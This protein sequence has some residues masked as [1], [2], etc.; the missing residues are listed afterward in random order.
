MRIDKLELRRFGKFTDQTL[1]FPAHGAHGG[2]YVVYGGNE[3]GKTTSLYA[4]RYGLYGF[5]NLRN[6]NPLIYHFLHGMPRL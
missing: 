6:N 4:I 2:L 5:P 3:A 1:S